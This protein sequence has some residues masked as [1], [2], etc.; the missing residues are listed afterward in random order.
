MR[1]RIRKY[2]SPDVRNLEEWRPPDPTCL[3]VLLQVLIGPTDDVGEESFDFMVCTPNWLRKEYG[4]DGVILG[5][6][7]VVV[8]HY[9]FAS[10]RARLERL[11]SSFDAST[12]DELAT[13][14]SRYAHWEFED[15]EGKDATP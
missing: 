8:F 5:R 4:D 6:A 7:H 9:K 13:K 1:A 3:G 15:Y 12:W 10:I 11:V 14:L 2:H